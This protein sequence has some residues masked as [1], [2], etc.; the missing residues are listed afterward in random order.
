[1]SRRRWLAAGAG[2]LACLTA[3]G[4]TLRA[5]SSDWVDRGEFGPFLC[6]SAVSLAP[7]QELFDELACLQLE[8]ERTLAVPPTGKTVDV[9]LLADER[10]HRRYLQQLYP[11][12]PYRRALYV[13]RAGRGAVY[14]YQHEALAIDLR[15]ECTHALLHGAMA[16]VPLWL[17]EGLAEYFEMPEQERAYGHP[18]LE[19]L[20][21]HRRMGIVQTIESLEQLE[22]LAQMGGAEYRFAWAWVHF[23][24]H[25]PLAAHRA[26]VEY[27][28]C[29]RAGQR[30]G[31]L[32]ASLR[33]AIPDLD[34]R[35][36]Q[37][38][39]NWKRS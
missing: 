2:A 38:F 22:D 7:L 1:M 27:V 5:A 4:R 16:D 33:A 25:G 18:H 12:V 17:D 24:L 36:V 15:H 31:A 28:A 9:L 19:M 13:Q 21:W 39:N 20:R 11:G 30:P 37:H 6:Q 32:S 23:M 29:L 3:P 8:L 14:V 34:A 10:N 35:L 26:L